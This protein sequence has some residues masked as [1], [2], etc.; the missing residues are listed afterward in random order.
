MRKASLKPQIIEYLKKKTGLAESTIRQNVSRFKTDYPGCTLNAVAQLFA[1][2][3][4][5]TVMQKLSQEDKNTLPNTEIV[6]PR[7]KI[8]QKDTRKKEKII[9]IIDYETND[10]FK[11]GHIEEI[12]RAYSKG[13]YTSVHILARKIVEN[14]VREVISSKFPAK[15]QQEKELYFDTSQKRFK[16]FSVV[17]KNLYNRRHDFDPEAIKVIERLYQKAQKFK[18]DSND[19]T[20]SW[21]HLVE[22]KKEIDDL[23]VQTII[24]LIK[25]LEQKEGKAGHGKKGVK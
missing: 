9:K 3:R 10:Y 12:N 6:K 20:H 4:N 13:C 16:D 22:S 25:K 23:N 8:R 24:E 1:R 2:S 11:K 21:Y 17:L 7:I 5:L 18:D 14:L 15:T 19:A